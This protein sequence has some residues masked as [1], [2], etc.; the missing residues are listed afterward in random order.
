MIIFW[1]QNLKNARLYSKY[2]G[3]KLE[4]GGNHP[5]L[6]DCYKEIPTVD[7]DVKQCLPCIFAFLRV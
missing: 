6:L 5:S 2:V 7:K 1:Y 3:T 4:Q